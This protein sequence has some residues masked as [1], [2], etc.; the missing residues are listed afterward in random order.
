MQFEVATAISHNCAMVYV[1]QPYFD[2]SLDPQVYSALK[3]AFTA[4]DDLTPMIRGTSPYFE[5]GL[6]SSERSFELDYSTYRDFSGAYAMLSQ[7]HWPFDVLTEQ[8]LTRDRLAKL[9]V[10][11]VPNIVHLSASQC[12]EVRNYIHAGG[13]AIFCYRSA[14]KDQLG[15]NLDQPSFG[16]LKIESESENQVSFVRPK[17]KISNRYLRTSAIAMFQTT[18]A[19]EVV[20]TI[21]DPSL[22]VTDMEWVSHNVMPGL[23]TRFPA[24]AAGQYGRGSFVYFGF[25]IFDDYVDQAQPALRETFE[26]GLRNLHQP[27]IWAEAPGNVEAVFSKTSNR[28]RIALV[29]GITSKVM[30]GDMWAGE[31]GVRGHVS[32]PEVVPVH[33]VTIRS[34]GRDILE[35]YDLKGTA[36]HI[37]RSGSVQTVVLPLLEQ[38]G[39]VELILA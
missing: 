13:K 5:I 33:N 28:L 22:R 25:R 39:L 18:E 17:W 36:L 3:A 37:S 26:I 6:L 16:V 27:T 12:S 14:T 4:A 10:L 32:I 24:I 21:T 1:D 30:T 20:A 8:D 31:K 9:P 34:N 29:N 7:L 19:S 35:A 2:G 38:Y 11:V 15:A 23:E